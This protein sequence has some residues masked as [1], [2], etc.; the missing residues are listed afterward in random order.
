MTAPRGYPAVARVAPRPIEPW[1]AAAWFGFLVLFPI[2]LFRS[3]LPQLSSGIMAMLMTVTLLRGRRPPASSLAPALGLA[4]FAWYTALVS[5][6]WTMIVG[7]LQIA[8][9]P[10]FYI[11]NTLVVLCFLMMYGEAGRPL[12]RVTMIA[13]AWSLLFQVAAGVLLPGG[14]REKATFNNPNQLGYYALLCGCI[15]LVGSRHIK[16]NRALL[17]SAY[18]AVFVLAAMSLSKAAIVAS[19]VLFVIA[20]EKRPA[21][22]VALLGLVLALT[23]WADYSTDMVDRVVDRFSQR[24]SD[25]NMEA[26]GYSR[27]LEH[28]QYLIFGAAEGANYRYSTGK[29]LHSTIG[30]VLYSYGAVGTVLF[31]V[32]V[33]LM[34]RMTGWR[35]LSYLVP[36]FAYGLTHQGLRFTMFWVLLAFII[37]C[38][39]DAPAARAAVPMKRRPV[40]ARGRTPGAAVLAPSAQ[41]RRP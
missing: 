17:L 28:P 34:G 33:F 8:R 9:Y 11:Y 26:R 16:I 37:A 13:V 30:T 12:L 3:G 19:V 27:I 38:G 20:T 23:M 21:V 4:A 1:M 31:A 2:Y 32:A 5:L 36:V 35:R 15:L 22:V 7:D 24:G 25:D 14:G 40:F 18:L 6:V 39:E 10:L 41:L 29:E